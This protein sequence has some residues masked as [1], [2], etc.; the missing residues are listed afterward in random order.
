M[1]ID[2]LNETVFSIPQKDYSVFGGWYA[3]KER[4]IP[5]TDADGRLLLGQE[6][7]DL[8]TGTFYAKWTAKEPLTYKLLMVF[9]E[10]VNASFPLT[11]GSVLTVD[12]KLSPTERKFVR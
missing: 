1:H 6:I 5:V 11:D 4:T 2:R 12:Y 10:E 8:D 7:F 9:A 3:D